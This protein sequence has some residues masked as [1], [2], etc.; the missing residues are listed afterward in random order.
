M[1]RARKDIRITN[2]EAKKYNGDAIETANPKYSVDSTSMY[3]KLPKKGDY[4]TYEVT[5]TNK[6]DIDYFNM[7]ISFL[8][9]N[10]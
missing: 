10:S 1:I 9:F 6:S 2:I 3:V 4:V 8:L 7:L 5:I